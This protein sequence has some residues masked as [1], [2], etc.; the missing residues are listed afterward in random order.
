MD[1]FV[2]VRPTGKAWSEALGRWEAQQADYAISEWVHFFRGEPRVK[3]DTEV[4]AADIASHNLVLFGD[5][6]SNAIYK[7]LSA[8]LPVQWRADGV[9]AGGETFDANHAPVFVFPN[10]LN[11]KKYVVIN[12]GF[13]FHDQ[14]N[15]DMQSPK[16]PDWAVVDITKPGNNYRY[17]PLHVASQGFFDEAWSFRT[18]ATHT[19]SA[20]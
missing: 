6:S 17:L 3:N 15:N 7:R 18:P 10:P 20:R 5:P 13:T 4:T 11:P 16:L 2:F 19:T 8:R 12:S 9:R 14:S 1:S